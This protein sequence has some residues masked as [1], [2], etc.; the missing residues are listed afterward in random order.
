MRL[1]RRPPP[2]RRRTSRSSRRL[3]PPIIAATASIARICLKRGI[4][5]SRPVRPAA[6]PMAVTVPTVSKKSTSTSENSSGTSRQSRAARTSA[7][8]TVSKRGHATMAPFH[9]MWPVW[10]A[11][12]ADTAIATSIAPA[13]PSAS[14]QAPAMKPTIAISGPGD[15]QSPAVTGGSVSPGCSDSA[16]TVDEGTTTI[17]AWTRPRKMM[18]RPMPTPMAR[19]R[20]TGMA[21]A[22]ASR[23]PSRTQARTIAPSS[24]MRPIAPRQPPAAGATWNATKAFSPI[25]GASAIGTFAPEPHEDRGQAGGQRRG[26]DRGVRGHAGRRQDRRVGHQDVGH[27]QERGQRAAGLASDGGA[28]PG[29]VEER[30][31]FAV[32]RCFTT[33]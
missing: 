14:R 16:A 28:A 26:G 8:N 13:R 10:S 20:S 17:C 22:T 19:R 30:G 31:H 24:T 29:E 3:A 33:S 18:N 23:S 21:R 7:W 2:T 5:P 9:A 12:S 1:R 15:D 25:P 11:S 32:R 27:R 4:M 6:S